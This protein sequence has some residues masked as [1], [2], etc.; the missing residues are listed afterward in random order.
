M[1]YH[2]PM[3]HKDGLLRIGFRI[4]ESAHRLLVL[5]HHHTGT[6]RVDVATGTMDHKLGNQV[7][8]LRVHSRVWNL[9]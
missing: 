1:E 2:I 5:V 8:E 4:L 7:I 9:R 6:G 3:L